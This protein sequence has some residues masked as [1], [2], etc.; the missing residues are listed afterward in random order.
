MPK[1]PK[2]LKKEG[3]TNASKRQIANYNSNIQ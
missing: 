3:K 2:V 1:Q